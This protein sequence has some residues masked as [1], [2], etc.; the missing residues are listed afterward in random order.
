MLSESGVR[1]L[2]EMLETSE[3]KVEVREGCSIFPDDDQLSPPKQR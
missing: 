3:S 2:V 1:S